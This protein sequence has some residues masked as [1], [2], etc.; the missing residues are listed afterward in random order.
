MKHGVDAEALLAPSIEQLGEMEADGLVR[1][2]PGEVEVTPAGQ[3]FVRNV[4]MAFDA[5]LD[6][7]PTDRKG[8]LPVFSRTV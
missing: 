7:M 4:A 2:A 1:L 3:T 8:R 6:R 5:W